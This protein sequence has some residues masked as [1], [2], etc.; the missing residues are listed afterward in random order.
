M[1]HLNTTIEAL[2]ERAK[3]IEQKG[4]ANYYGPQRFGMDYDNIRV[5]VEMLKGFKRIK[6]A[7]K[8]ALYSSSIQSALFNILLSRRIEAK[9]S[10]MPGDILKKTDTGGLFVND[11]LIVNKQRLGAA[12]IT[13]CGPMFGYKMMPT[14]GEPH[15]IKM[16][17]L[18]AISSWN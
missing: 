7:H 10:L 6:S 18:E 11:D 9:Q 8:R 14:E 13:V 15:Q 5:G 4:F 17:L 2:Q 16:A 3:I 12:E 1:R